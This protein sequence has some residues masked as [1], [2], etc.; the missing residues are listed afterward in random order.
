MKIEL[1]FNNKALPPV[2]F[3]SES[4]RMQESEMRPIELR[5]PYGSSI[6]RNETA[7]SI[8]RQI[9]YAFICVNNTAT[10]EIMQ[11]K[12]SDLWFLNKIYKAQTT[13]FGKGTIEDEEQKYDIVIY[14]IT[15]GTIT[16]S[17]YLTRNQ[18][19]Q[20]KKISRGIESVSLNSKLVQE[21]YG[22]N[23]NTE[24]LVEQ[25]KGS[26]AVDILGMIAITEKYFKGY[27]IAWNPLTQYIILK[28]D[29]GSPIH[30]DAIKEND[31]FS[32]I[33]LFTLL[34]EKRKHIGVFYINAGNITT[35]VLQ[36]LLAL[37]KLSFGSRAVVFIYN[38][39]FIN[40]DAVDRDVL[41]LPNYVS[42][43]RKRGNVR[44]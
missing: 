22:N 33:K 26:S 17:M 1:L 13:S 41:V 34:L 30:Y 7:I 35:P 42:E 12:I 37:I 38:A 15:A 27:H 8:L 25:S 32:A 5:I 20:R 21:Q 40:K 6:S 18:S 16:E 23:L 14:D 24:L 39:Q 28:T 31:I 43:G 3:E 9:E 10:D 19:I 44:N 11:L 29:E 2:N 4:G 36:G